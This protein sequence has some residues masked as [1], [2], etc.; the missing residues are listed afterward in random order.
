MCVCVGGGGGPGTP[1]LNGL[2]VAAVSLCF[3]FL[4][5]IS[6]IDGWDRSSGDRFS[7]AED[8]L[9]NFQW[10]ASQLRNKS[11]KKVEL[12]R[13]REDLAANICTGS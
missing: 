7:V 5:W 12:H 6:E 8:A 10:N 13:K 11:K 3:A 9:Q 4:F 2:P 1:T